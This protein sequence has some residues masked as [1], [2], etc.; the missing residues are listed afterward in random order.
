MVRLN[1]SS[2]DVRNFKETTVFVK[3][4]NTKSPRSQEQVKLKKGLEKYLKSKVIMNF[5]YF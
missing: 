1:L 4:G 2:D 3:E 5:K